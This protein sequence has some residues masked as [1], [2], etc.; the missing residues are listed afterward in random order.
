MF[1]RRVLPI[2]LI[3]RV[4]S[5]RK[6]A[7]AK[8]ECCSHRTVTAE[9]QRSMPTIS[10]DIPAMEQSGGARAPGSPDLPLLLRDLAQAR[11]DL[12]YGRPK[13]ECTG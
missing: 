12:C 11:P 13:M 6:R 2:A 1:R 9:A 3:R 4:H 10:S 5:G 7:C 8:N